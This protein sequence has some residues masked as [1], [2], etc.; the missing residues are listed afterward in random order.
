MTPHIGPLALIEQLSFLCSL[1]RVLDNSGMNIET[2]TQSQ[3][4][5]SGAN[6]ARCGRELIPGRTFSFK[7]AGNRVVSGGASPGTEITRCFRCA[8]QQG[9]MLNRSLAAALVVGAVLTLLNQGDA[10]L[11]GNWS[12]ALL[13]KI[14][15]TCCVPMLVA[16]YLDFVQN[17][18]ESGAPSFR[19]RPE[20]RGV[21]GSAWDHLWAPASA[22]ATGDTYLDPF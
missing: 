8:L 1:A 16:A 11:L 20:S 4:G 2:D 7:S 19:R 14:P 15:L 3:V 5:I 21:S 12:N 18:P 13:W 9:P 22:G 17:L 10:L 6:C